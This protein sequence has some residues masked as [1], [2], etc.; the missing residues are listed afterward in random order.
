VLTSFIGRKREIVE[1]RGLLASSRLVT[2]TGTAG[3]GKT[4]LALRVA[5]EV[6]RQCEDGV[7]WVELAR[8]ADPALVPRATAKVLHVAEQHGRPTVQ[9][10]LAA[11]HRKH[12]LLVL[13]NCDHVLSACTQLVET[14]I[15]T[16]E[17]SILAT[18]PKGIRSRPA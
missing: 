2:L 15:A 5:A 7:H 4:R 16:T 9:G 17:V 12:L 18:S 13:D 14:L 10:L 3:C 1:V 11:L 8:L 6:S